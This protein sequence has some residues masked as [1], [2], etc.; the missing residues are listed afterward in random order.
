MSLAYLINIARLTFR[1]R[2]PNW[3]FYTLPSKYDV[4]RAP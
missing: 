4:L 2:L 1:S 3:K